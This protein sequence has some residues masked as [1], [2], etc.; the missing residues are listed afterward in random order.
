MSKD[1]LPG[2]PIEIKKKHLLRL[3]QS[4]PLGEHLTIK[5]CKLLAKIAHYRS[6]KKGEI[7]AEEAN[8]RGQLF[9][10]VSGTVE[11]DL[12]SGDAINA[13][14]T[15]NNEFM[16][17]LLSTGQMAG[18]FGLLKDT[19]STATLRVDEPCQVVIFPRN[20]L[21]RLL[22]NNPKAGVKILL[23]LIRVVRKLVVEMNQYSRD[24]N[25]FVSG[26]ES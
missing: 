1:R 24:M 19:A 9:Y 3:I 15:D 18:V 10:I 8:Y 26:T 17:D 4:S 13:A 20:S 11:V 23:A 16:L 25:K 6:L 7:L 5:D 2:T 22:K 14:D 12:R 21:N